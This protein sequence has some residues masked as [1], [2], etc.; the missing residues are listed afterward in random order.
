MSN[1]ALKTVKIGDKVNVGKVEGKVIN[2]QDNGRLAVILLENGCI[3]SIA[4][5]S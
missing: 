3:K 2:V 5:E 4:V 1:A